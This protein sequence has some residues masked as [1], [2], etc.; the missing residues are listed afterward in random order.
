[1]N[2]VY[3]TDINKYRDDIIN[4]F[5]DYYG[6]KYRKIITKRYNNTNFYIFH[7]P[8]SLD[9]Y[10]EY[11]YEHNYHVKPDDELIRYNNYLDYYYK[12]LAKVHDKYMNQF[13]KDNIDLLPK[14]DQKEFSGHNYS[15]LKHIDLIID[16]Y[17][18]DDY[19]FSFYNDIDFKRYFDNF[20]NIDTYATYIFGGGKIEESYLK[21][22]EK[23]NIKRIDKDRVLKLYMS[24]IKMIND[25]SRY[26][27]SFS[28]SQSKCNYD[29]S[30]KGTIN[31]P[32]LV[33]RNIN[34][35]FMANE[36][37]IK[38]KNGKV[39]YKEERDIYYCPENS[40]FDMQD[41]SLIHEIAHAINTTYDHKTNLLESITGTCYDRLDIANNCDEESSLLDEII[42]DKIAQDIT[43]KLHDKGIYIFQKTEITKHKDRSFYAQFIPAIEPYFNKNKDLL[44][45]TFMTGNLDLVRPG[46]L[47]E[48]KNNK[49]SNRIDSEYGKLRNGVNFM[50]NIVCNKNEHNEYAKQKEF[51]KL[52]QKLKNNTK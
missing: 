22:N 36:K 49:F 50:F 7:N 12:F 24:R 28:F 42:N 3:S 19:Y 10:I 4:A 6:E 20:G 11:E 39:T 2:L 5:V 43:D 25:I 35:Y 51:K 34:A 48:L 21:C 1:M 41:E 14:S 47:E 45:E 37:I 33:S 31:K 52:S 23:K 17:S 46:E 40:L 29:K 18:F 38:H 27:T 26:M 30:K 44:I 15:S 13:V 9:Q 32:L 16:P 8:T